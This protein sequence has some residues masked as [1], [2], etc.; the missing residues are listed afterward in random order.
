MI[1]RSLIDGCEKRFVD[2]KG[3]TPATREDA[4]ESTS[5]RRGATADA[6]A[7]Y[8]KRET[9]QERVNQ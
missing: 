8:R 5:Q 6:A 3:M 7:V 2:S 4:D 1:P 9:G